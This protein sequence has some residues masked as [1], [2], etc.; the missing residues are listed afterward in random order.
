MADEIKIVGLKRLTVKLARM[1]KDIGN[2][3][4]MGQIGA[5]VNLGIKTRTARGEN[6]DGRTLLDYTP[7]YAKRRS[8][9][10]HPVNKVN[11]FFTGSMF[12][13]LTY[14]AEKYQVTSFFM[15]TV[16]K[17]GGRNPEK[18]FFNDELRPFFGLSD[19]DI[20]EIES[21]VK[22]H[23]EKLLRGKGKK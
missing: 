5:F 21:M 18:A 13:A 1:G 16:D 9:A 11:L 12:S 23:L 4:L 15:N 10:G 8:K 3:R 17:Y 20:D 14:D 7:E 2:A 19:A 22:A 6:M